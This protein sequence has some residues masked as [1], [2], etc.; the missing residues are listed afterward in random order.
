MS[1]AGACLLRGVLL[2]CPDLAGTRGKNKSP[3]WYPKGICAH[4][5][6]GRVTARWRTILTQTQSLHVRDYSVTLLSRQPARSTAWP[7]ERDSQVFKKVTPLRPSPHTP[8]S[9]VYSTQSSHGHSLCQILKRQDGVRVSWSL[10]WFQVT[11]YAKCTLRWS[12][13]EAHSQTRYFC[14][15]GASE[16]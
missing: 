8:S 10:Q 14:G 2:G 3:G 9:A 1:R 13:W 6:L 12:G 5:Q 4:F 15:A 11:H 16:C 7:R